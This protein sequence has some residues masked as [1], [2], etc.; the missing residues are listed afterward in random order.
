MRYDATA[1][2]MV[3]ASLAAALVLAACGP[4]DTADNDS[5]N[6]TSS[7][8]SD[9]ARGTVATDM[10]KVGEVQ[11]GKKIGAD[12]KV[13]E[14]TT[15]FLPRD[16][17]YVSVSTTGTAT[18]TPLMLMVTS[19]ADSTQ[20]A[21][22]NKSVSATAPMVTEFHFSKPEGFKVGKY[23]AEIWLNNALVETKEFEVKARAGNAG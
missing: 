9:S 7:L 10:I 21:M 5:A 17:V 16:T 15:E 2:R 3:A 11:L 22:E 18:N 12:M 1:S 8:T 23:R 20:V 14:P 19:L 13:S 4:R 6:D